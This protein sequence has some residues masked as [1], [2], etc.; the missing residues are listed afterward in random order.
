MVAQNSEKTVRG[1]PFQAGEDSRRN[2]GG[3]PKAD[4]ATKE[5][6]LAGGPEAAQ[7]MVDLLHDESARTSDRLRAAEYILDRLLGKAVQ[8]ILAE[9]HREDEPMTLD[10]MFD[11]VK[12]IYESTWGG[13]GS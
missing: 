8:P 12:E 13:K 1:R 9:V 4:P 7:F 3:R 6:L 11:T 10:E 2:T 5:I